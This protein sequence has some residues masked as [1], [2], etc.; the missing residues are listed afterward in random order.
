VLNHTSCRGV[1]ACTTKSPEDGNIHTRVD[2]KNKLGRKHAGDEQGNRASTLHARVLQW[3]K[4]SGLGKE[5]KRCAL[6][7][8]CSLRLRTRLDL[9]KIFFHSSRY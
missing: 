1:R 9:G 8:D 2:E 6:I 7:T 3:E 4:D 5:E